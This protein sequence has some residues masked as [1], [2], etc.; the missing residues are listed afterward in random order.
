LRGSFHGGLSWD[1]TDVITRSNGHATS[2]ETPSDKTVRV[3]LNERG[4]WQVR[5]PDRSDPVTCSTLE[6]AR[7]V[8]KARAAQLAQC[9][10]IYFDAYHRVQHH[11]PPPST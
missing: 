5:V 9:D 8:V 11:E 4:E 6:E 1:F 10:V 2:V 7:D 3:D